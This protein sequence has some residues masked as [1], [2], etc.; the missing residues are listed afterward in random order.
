MTGFASDAIIPKLRFFVMGMLVLSTLLPCLPE[1][2]RSASRKFIHPFGVT[3]W[4]SKPQ[5]HKTTKPQLIILFFFRRHRSQSGRRFFLLFFKAARPALPGGVRSVCVFFCVFFL[6]CRVV[7]RRLV[8]DWTPD[9]AIGAVAA[10]LCDS[11]CK[12][13]GLAADRSGLR[14]GCAS[15]AWG[16]HPARWR[17]GGMGASG[18]AKW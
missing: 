4:A 15:R 5:N 12:Q 3:R 18:R 10:P 17:Q 16:L 8:A 1:K 2:K 7:R 14:R 13:H 9:G 6:S 11:L